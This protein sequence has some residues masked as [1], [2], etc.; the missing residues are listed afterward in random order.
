MPLPDLGDVCI[1]GGICKQ[2]CW[3]YTLTLDFFLLQYGTWNEHRPAAL[4]SCKVIQHFLLS[5]IISQARDNPANITA[6]NLTALLSPGRFMRRRDRTCW[7]A[8]AL[9]LVDWPAFT[10]N[11]HY[12]QICS[13]KCAKD[14]NSS[15]VVFMYL[16]NRPPNSMAVF[17]CV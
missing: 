9:W 12:V 1:L 4:T 13:W 8:F 3:M 16:P 11:F 5:M 17:R 14:W 2:P 15:K 6:L 7:L 10:L